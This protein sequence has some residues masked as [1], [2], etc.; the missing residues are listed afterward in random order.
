[1]N[2]EAVAL[3]DSVVLKRFIGAGGE[4]ERARHV[5]GREAAAAPGELRGLGPYG[6]AHLGV[7]FKSQ[8][9]VGVFPG[10]KRRAAAFFEREPR[11]LGGAACGD[12]E[13]VFGHEELALGEGGGIKELVLVPDA[14]LAGVNHKGPGGVDAGLV[15][16]NVDAVKARLIE[17][18]EGF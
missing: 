6:H 9:V 5:A 4:G 7:G 16:R 14:L 3:Q 2:R 18:V 17:R 15:A 8:A 10:L 12:A 1:M 13:F 11:A